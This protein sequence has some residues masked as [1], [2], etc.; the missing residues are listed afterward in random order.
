MKRREWASVRTSYSIEREEESRH[1]TS[2]FMYM[3]KETNPKMVPISNILRKKRN[4]INRH[5]S[6]QFLIY[7][8]KRKYQPEG[9]RKD[10]IIVSRQKNKGNSLDNKS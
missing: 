5:T 4:S 8:R 7:V 6:G 10:L 1:H 3:N 2:F 9:V